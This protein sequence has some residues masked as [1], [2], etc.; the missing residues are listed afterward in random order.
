[1]AFFFNGTSYIEATSTPITGAPFT[2][3][4]WF[5]PNVQSQSASLIHMGLSSGSARFQ[6]RTDA[7]SLIFQ[8][9]GGGATTSA[10]TPIETWNN[11]TWFHATAVA[12]S[13]IS[14]FIY[15]N[16]GGKVQ[17]TTSR[18]PA[19]INNTTIGAQIVGGTRDNFFNGD[20]AEPAIWNTTLTDDEILSLSK[21]FA[22]S[23]IRPTNLKF[24]NRCIRTPK[25]LYGGL[26]FTSVNLTITDHP[27]IY[28]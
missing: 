24:Y 1:M 11:P 4:C 21:G 16:G 12:F 26:N 7:N 10:S 28:G 25:D 17:N 14:R 19:G 9:G 20:I 15:F 18:T 13:P 3:A 22:P 8:T 6:M 23:L 2:M 5:K 27:R